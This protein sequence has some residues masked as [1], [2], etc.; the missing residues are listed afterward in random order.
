[1]LTITKSV[2]SAGSYDVVV[3]GGGPSGWVAATAAAR[4]GCRTAVIER[5]GFFGGTATAGLVVP[6]S[7]FFK[8][9]TRVVGGIPWEFIG[10]ME[11]NGAAVLEMPKGHISVDTE[12]YKLIAQRIVVASGVDIFMNSYISYVI[13][14]NGHVSAVIIENKGGSEAVEGR[15]FVDATG[16]GDVLWMAGADMDICRQPQP[17]SLCF[18]LIGLDC[19]TPL[20]KDSIHHDGRS[21]HS[22]NTQINRFLEKEYRLGTCPMFGGPWFN[23]LVKGDRI[24]VNITRSP[25]TVLDN[26][27][28]AQAEFQLRE[29][30]FALTEILREHYP[31]FHG[32]TISSSAVNAGV[33]ES[34]HLKGRYTITGQELLSGKDFPD[35]IARNAHP[36]DIHG[37]EAAGQIL[38]D[39]DKSGHIPY[40]ALI[41]PKLDN[42]IAGGRMLSADADAHA[43]IRVQGTV[44]AVGQAAG[45][46]AAICARENVSVG[47]IHIGRL[48]ET[49]MHS[50]AIC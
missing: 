10:Q 11:K 35:S 40:R 7:G 42:V 30:M 47:E 18:E 33:R 44:M 36:V 24:A 41:S 45:T 22:V 37:N 25:A 49:L 13:E 38:K 2:P 14:N 26:R 34:R 29:D 15:V 5:F 4:A 23:T 20:L 50:G 28:Y 43:S 6:V 31:E 27:E 3:C 17:L 32:C 46:A 48:R 19:T 39:S 9:G 21:G 12:Y 1:M 8:N 16:D